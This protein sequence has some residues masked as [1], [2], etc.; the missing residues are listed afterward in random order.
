MSALLTEADLAER[1]NLELKEVA[2]LR[3]KHHWECVRFGRFKVRYTEAQ[4][5]RI[6]ALHTV[7][8]DRPSS[9]PEQTSLSARR[10]A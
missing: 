2:S 10:S 8:A 7:K 1:L 6:V 3:A 5:E 4:A 9:L